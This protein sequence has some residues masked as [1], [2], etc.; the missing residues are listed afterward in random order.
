MTNTLL[1]GSMVALVTP[2]KK[3]LSIDEVSLRALV[4]W[5]V[6]SGTHAI[7]PCGTTG[8]SATLTHDE[9]KQV[10]S[11]VV[12]QANKRVPV[13]AGAGSNSTKE[14]L[15]LHAHAREAGADAALHITPYYNKP[16]QDGLKAHFLTLADSSDLPIVLYNVPGRTGV[17]MEASTTIELSRHENIVAVKEASGSLNQASEILDSVSHEFSFLSGEDAFTFPLYALGANG[18]I[19]VTANVRPKEMSD[20]WKAI[21]KSDYETARQLHYALMPL[22]QGLFC[23]TNPIPVKTALSMMGKIGEHFRLPLTSISDHNRESLKALL[24]RFDLLF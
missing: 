23:E 1:S 16:T 13:I 20:Q 11:I 9:H 21:E 4:D 2:M 10:I 17:N 19:S 15:E 22:H 6:D 5:H 24:S 7:V 3:D 12:D 14:A 8:E 18:V